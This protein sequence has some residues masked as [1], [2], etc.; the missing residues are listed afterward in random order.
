[1]KYTLRVLTLGISGSGKTTF[2]KQMK[3]ITM[4]GFNENEIQVHKLI[5]RQN[6]LVGIQELA[7]Q[8]EKLE[9]PLK[10]ENRKRCRY[11]K[12]LHVVEAEWNEHL[13]DK[14]RI[15]WR[16]PAIQRTWNLS[17]SFQLQMVHLD[18]LMD[19]IDRIAQPD[20][21]PIHDDMLRARQRTTGDTLISFKIDH[22]VWEMIDVGG[23]K[24]ERVKWEKI[25]TSTDINAIIFFAALDEFNMISIE[26]SNKT[27]M[28]ISLQTFN[29][30]LSS[31][32]IRSRPQITLLLFLNKTDL[33]KIKLNNQENRQQ[34]KEIF[35]EFKGNESDE[36]KDLLLACE[37]VNR[38]FTNSF[39]HTEIHTHYIC[40]LNT[41]LMEVV[42]RTVRKTILQWR[43]ITA[44][45]KF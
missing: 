30:I 34:F 32:S 22:N 39:V 26:E 21:I 27:K 3:I 33:L 16:D 12:Q 37:C 44:G 9:D 5:I 42:F 10:P 31:E 4:G 41:S 8:T 6:I 36:E 40:A 2:A 13:V 25:I 43:M 38:K 7:K 20:Y 45:F 18:Y 29:E 17:T 14:L 1:V 11:F 35:P 23:Q 24:P 19:N 28:E 15:L